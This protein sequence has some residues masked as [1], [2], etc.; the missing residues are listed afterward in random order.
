MEFH[1]G[2]KQLDHREAADELFRFAERIRDGLHANPLP[3]DTADILDSTERDRLQGFYRARLSNRRIEAYETKMAEEA[4]Q[5]ISEG[6]QAAS[7]Q[8]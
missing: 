1:D 8:P 7:H 2:S 4:L 3:Q 6:Q 5:S